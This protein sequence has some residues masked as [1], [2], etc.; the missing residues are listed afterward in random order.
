MPRWSWVGRVTALPISDR[1]L[2]HPRSRTTGASRP[3]SSRQFSRPS[4][5]AL[6]AVCAHIC[7][8]RTSPGN[9]T[10]NSRSG[11]V[12]VGE[13]SGNATGSWDSAAVGRNNDL[14]AGEPRMPLLPPL[15]DRDR[16]PEVM[17]EPGLDPGDH[18]RALARAGGSTAWSRSVAAIWPVVEAAAR[19]TNGRPVRVFDL[20]C[21]AGDVLVGLWQKAAKA[22]VPVALDGCDV[23]AVA[24]EH[25]ARRRPRPGRTVRL[26]QADALRDILPDGYDVVCALAVPAP[27][28]GR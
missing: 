1:P 24:L 10:P 3:N 17:D 12:M 5:I 21:G 25:A 2:P 6:S 13:N 26:F 28:G 18:H 8:G 23:S 15:R 22:G 19:R 7:G 16:R 4:G 11:W 20:A 27:P 9:G 14:T